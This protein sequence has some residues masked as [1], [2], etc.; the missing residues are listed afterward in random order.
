[1]FSLTIAFGNISCPLLFKT[2]ERADTAWNLVDQWNT[3][4]FMAN[5]ANRMLELDDDFG[6]W[7]RT[8]NL[9]GAV[10][11]DLEL[12]K[13]GAIETALH[14][15]RLQHGAQKRAATDPVLRSG[16]AMGGQPAMLSPMA[17]GR[18]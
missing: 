6:R 3:H 8:D 16:L 7:I 18:F 5:N 15:A 2:K 1:M 13:E 12:S 11:E 10:M 4:K 17:N 9:T 14:Q